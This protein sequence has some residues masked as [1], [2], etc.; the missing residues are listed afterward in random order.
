MADL[1][2][3]IILNDKLEKA[4]VEAEKIVADFLG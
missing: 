4:L 2:D 3:K 1:F